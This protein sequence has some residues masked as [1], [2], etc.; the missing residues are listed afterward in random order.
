MTCPSL[1]LKRLR[2]LLAGERPFAVLLPQ[3]R[4]ISELNRVFTRAVPPGVARVC[5]LVALQGDTAV[6]FCAHGSAAARLRS[7]TRSIA[8]ALST[9]GEPVRVIMV[10]V[11]VDWSAPEHPQ[12]AGMAPAALEAWA[13][14][15]ASLPEGAL[16]N[17]VARLLRHQRMVNR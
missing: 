6:V 16:K 3:A 7:Q 14:L 15:Q 1:P 10:K 12:K 4:R 13:E 2:N 9:T 5:R 11:R 17:A 8:A